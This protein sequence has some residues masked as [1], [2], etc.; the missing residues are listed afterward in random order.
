MKGTVMKKTVLKKAVL[1]LLLLIIGIYILQSLYLTL[2]IS[3]LKSNKY[4]DIPYKENSFISEE[5]YNRLASSPNDRHKPRENMNQIVTD[6][7]RTDFQLTIIG[8]GKAYYYGA[9]EQKFRAIDKNNEEIFYGS[10][11][12][13]YVNVEFK[14]FHWV[15][16]KVWEPA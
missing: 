10:V 5:F 15:V 13:L 14:N 11:A 6:Y 16:V 3:A 1:I 8:L 12:P 7:Y 2:L 9:Y 4:E